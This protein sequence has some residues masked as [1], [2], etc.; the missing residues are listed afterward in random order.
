M[1]VRTRI[2]DGRSVS[3][4]A[5][6]SAAVD[7]CQVVAVCDRL[8]VPAIRL[9]AARTILG[10]GEIGSSR[11]RHMVVVIEVDQLAELQMAGEGC[12]LRGDALHQVA[13]A[14][15]PVCEMIDDLGAGAVVT[16]G[17]VR[18]GDRQTHSVAKA[19]TERSGGR[20]DAWC[21]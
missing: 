1:W 9:E 12:G 11:Q 15:D 10:E 3:P 17:Q 4:R 8:D 13:V 16:S 19:L 7:S 6:R 20:L 5:A 18:F 14:D 2:S 21:P